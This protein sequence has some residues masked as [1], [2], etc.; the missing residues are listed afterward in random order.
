MKE[1]SEVV[2]NKVC[3]G[4]DKLNDIALQMIVADKTKKEMQIDIPLTYNEGA[5]KLEVM[6]TYCNIRVLNELE[7]KTIRLVKKDTL[8]YS[9][10]SIYCNR[11]FMLGKDTRE[12]TLDQIMD[13]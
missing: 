11:F 12:H 7:G 13:G 5:A 1:L 2:V 4:L 6:L 9:L 3:I 10:G 8:P